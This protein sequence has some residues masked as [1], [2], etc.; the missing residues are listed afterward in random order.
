[1]E[2]P[3]LNRLDQTTTTTKKPKTKQKQQ[4]KKKQKNSTKT[5]SDFWKEEFLSQMLLPPMRPHPLN[6][7]KHLHQLGTK[8][9]MPESMGAFLIQGSTEA[10]TIVD[11]VLQSHKVWNSRCVHAWPFTLWGI[12]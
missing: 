7:P 1:M 2:K 9:Y 8:C 4:K 3:C 12:F 11:P 6:I 5:K 10:P